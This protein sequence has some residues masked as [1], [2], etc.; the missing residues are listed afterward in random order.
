MR[1]PVYPASKSWRWADRLC[2]EEGITDSSVY[3]D[4]ALQ[5]L[6][7]C[8]F[9]MSFTI[10]CLRPKIMPIRE[11]ICY[12]ANDWFRTRRLPSSDDG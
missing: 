9:C 6:T 1:F 12:I 11:H 4:K 10:G 7:E 2:L 5:A 8:K 3:L